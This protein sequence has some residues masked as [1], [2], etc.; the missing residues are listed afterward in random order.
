MAAKHLYRDRAVTEARD[1]GWVGFRTVPD[2]EGMWKAVYEPGENPAD[3]YAKAHPTWCSHGESSWASASSGDEDPW[4]IGVLVCTCDY[5]ALCTMG[6]VTLDRKL[7]RVW[8]LP[9]DTPEGTN[10]FLA[11][12]LDG[13]YWECFTP[14]VA[15]GGLGQAAPAAPGATAAPALRTTPV[16]RGT[17]DS[18]VKRVWAMA[19]GMPGATRAEV[20]A[21]CVAEGINKSTAGTQYYH[22]QK[23]KQVAANG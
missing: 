6:A 7:A 3:E 19:D 2:G 14:K 5:A 20:V 12:R 8:L 13:A 1:A 10:P 16:A 23:A 4:R 17:A 11:E 9:Y 21:A 18:P 22:W 15:T